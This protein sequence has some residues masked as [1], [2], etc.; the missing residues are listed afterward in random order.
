VKARTA[1]VD[2]NAESMQ[3]RVRFIGKVEIRWM[4]FFACLVPKTVPQASEYTPVSVIAA[5][6]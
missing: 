5:T 6:A 3:S 4:L 2:L 1:A